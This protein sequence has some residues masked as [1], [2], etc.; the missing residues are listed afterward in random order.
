MTNILIF[1]FVGWFVVALIIGVSSS[2]DGSLRVSDRGAV[3]GFRKSAGD[4]IFG[5]MLGVWIAVGVPIQY[6]MGLI[7]AV[8]HHKPIPDWA[9][10]ALLIGLLM[11]GGFGGVMLYLEPI[12]LSVHA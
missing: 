9:Y 3:M 6:G 7:D 11:G 8:Q 1:V 5:A 4:R 10:F 2:R 12:L